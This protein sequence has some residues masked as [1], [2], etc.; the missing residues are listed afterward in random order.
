MSIFDITL[1]KGAMSALLSEAGHTKSNAYATRPYT[2]I[3][4]IICVS[5]DQI[6]GQSLVGNTPGLLHAPIITTVSAIS[7][8][9]AAEHALN[10]IPNMIADAEPNK[11]L[12]HASISALFLGEQVDLAEDFCGVKEIDFTVGDPR[13]T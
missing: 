8:A 4:A 13:F 11:I 7:V 12:I 2:V 5:R 9:Q 1:P 3:L 10:S 6:E